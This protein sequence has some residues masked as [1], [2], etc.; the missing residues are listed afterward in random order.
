MVYRFDILRSF[1]VFVFFSH[2]SSQIYIRISCYQPGVEMEQLK[3][4][5]CF[6]SY[7]DVRPSKC[8]VLSFFLVKHIV[9]GRFEALC[10]FIMNP[11]LTILSLSENMLL[12]H[13]TVNTSSNIKYISFIPNPYDW[14]PFSLC[15]YEPM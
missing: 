1:G 8:L 7:V 12:Y 11:Y 5:M 14:K 6:L 3:L 4:A 9:R 10:W 15:F 2:P 13:H